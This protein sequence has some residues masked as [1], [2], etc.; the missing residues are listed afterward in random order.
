LLFE[1]GRFHFQTGVVLFQTGT[2]LFQIGTMLFQ[3]GTGL[4]CSGRFK[5]DESVDAVP[6]VALR[7][8]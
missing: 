3:I 5:S 6:D 4:L 1:N 8:I 2:M 7:Q